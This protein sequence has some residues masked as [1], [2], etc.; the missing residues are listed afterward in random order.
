MADGCHGTFFVM[1]QRSYFAYMSRKK[2][3]LI[4]ADNFYYFKYYH[5]FS[6]KNTI[7]NNKFKNKATI[8]YKK[9]YHNFSNNKSLLYNNIY[10]YMNNYL[11]FFSPLFTDYVVINNSYNIKYNKSILTGL[12]HDNLNCII[13]KK[14]PAI[15]LKIYDDLSIICYF[16]HNFLNKFEDL[17]KKDIYHKK[18]ANF[19]VVK[20]KINHK[21]KL[22]KKANNS[23]I[24]TTYQ[25]NTFK[26]LY[27][28]SFYNDI[29][30]KFYDKYKLL[31][32]TQLKLAIFVQTN[33]IY[34]V[35]DLLFK[36]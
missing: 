16:E 30:V 28:F 14:L 24:E 33:N 23:I 25:K 19:C 20:H 9:L 3:R 34:S 1:N 8:Y 27:E 12:F 35:F 29:T 18:S 10:V 21:F 17:I 4:R 36:K 26:H 11:L 32:H 13:F 15:Q 7:K 6:N 31:G 2:S 22:N 5:I